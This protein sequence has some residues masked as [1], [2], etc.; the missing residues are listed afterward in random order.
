MTFG[1]LID[2]SYLQTFRT[3]VYFYIDPSRLN[4][5]YSKNFTFLSLFFPL[6]S[7]NVRV[8]NEINKRNALN[9]DCLMR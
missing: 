3:D 4:S 7:E 5:S 9:C 1:T 6:P 2:I 8:G